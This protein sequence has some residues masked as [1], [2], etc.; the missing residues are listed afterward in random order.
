MS[1]RRRLS[2]VDTQPPKRL[3]TD[4]GR[5]ILTREDYSFGWVAAL[6][7]ER[8]AAEA[9]LDEKHEPLP[10]KAGDP[11]NYCYGRIGNHNVVVATLPFDGAGTVNAASVANNM[12]RS[13]PGLRG[14]LMVGIAGGVGERDVRLGDVVVG[15]TVVQYD[16]GRAMPDGRFELKSIPL[17]PSPELQ[18]AIAVLNAKHH[19]GASRI[20]DIIRQ[21]SKDY[22]AMKEFTNKRSL[23]DRLFDPTYDHVGSKGTCD[24]CD[25]SKL[26]VR[27]RR[28]NNKPIIHHGVVASGNTLMRS[29][30]MRNELVKEHKALC[31]EMES[32]G[33]IESLKCLAIRSI[34][35]YADSHKNDQWQKYAAAT[36]SAYAKELLG[37][38]AG[39]ETQSSVAGG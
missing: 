37:Q 26:V 32:A 39:L 22:P 35:D 11:N 15:T 20:P 12:H 24:G 7:I 9:V 28:P 1:S 38:I 33:F 10:Q 19:M 13:F 29:A 27:E 21:I 4:P 5:N 23:Q 36:A 2:D 30:K 17:R 8:A 18:T 3:R 16:L 34:C 6:D 31:F 25:S 14:Y